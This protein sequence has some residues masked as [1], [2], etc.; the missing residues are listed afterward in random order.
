VSDGTNSGTTLLKDIQSGSSGSSPNSLYSAGSLLYFQAN[1]GTAG[2]E[3]WTSDGSASGTTM[4][5]DINVGAGSS[6]AGWF[7]KL[8]SWV[9]F[10]A[11]DTT[12]NESKLWRTDGTAAN[13]ALFYNINFPF[14]LSNVGSRIVFMAGPAGVRGFRMWSTNGTAAG[15][16]EIE[17]FLPGDVGYFLLDNFPVHNGRVFFW[18]DDNISGQELW[19]SDGTSAGTVKYDIA[20][21]VASSYPRSAKGLNPLIF[22]ADDGSLSGKEPWVLSLP[23]PLSITGLEFNAEKRGPTAFLQWNT[24]GS[25][26]DYNYEVQ[27]GSNGLSF[28]AIGYLHGQPG[29]SAY[30]FT[31]AD[32]MDGKNYYRLKQTDSKGGSAFSAVRSVAF[33]ALSDVKTYPNP[34]DQVLHINTGHTFGS[35][36]LLVRSMGGQ[37]VLQQDVSGG[38]PVNVNIGRLPAGVYQA[39]LSEGSYSIKLM[40]VK[41]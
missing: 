24:S 40:F 1:N 16:F 15:T 41:R 6:E 28:S 30:S 3:V 34:A 38:G 14:L 22:S 2:A 17:D 20:P 18:I 39:E 23:T 37:E 26:G 32:P 19:S 36:K 25:S 9:Y 29:I 10:S 4:L 33:T 13:T 5:K 12:N 7:A 21:G 11:K 8:G 31:D 27:R 35:G